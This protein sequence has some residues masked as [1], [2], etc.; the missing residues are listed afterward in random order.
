M[1]E[2]IRDVYN[3][4]PDKKDRDELFEKWKADQSQSNLREV[5]RGLEPTI[6]SAVRQYA[7]KDAPPTVQQRARILAARAV[8]SYDPTRGANLNT[9][10]HN[11][12]R[13]IQRMAP[14]ISDP[15]APNE[16]FRRQQMEISSAMAHIEDTLGREPT[17]EE[18]AEAT[19]LPAKRV[20]KVR[21]RMRARIP[22]SVYEDASDDE[23][24]APDI[25]GS[26]RT[27]YDEWIDA[28]YDDLGPVDRLIMMYRT[29]YR[30]A[31]ILDNNTIAQ[32]LKLSPSAVSQR[33][34]RIQSRLD[35]FHG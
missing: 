25:I 21:N 11:Q 32:R 10:V 14:S 22:I 19:G 26:E 33:V 20:T 35:S 23:D 12:L 29:G 7:G 2:T 3:E 1:A 8:R 18:V 28:V 30:G 34:R 9:H 31:D 17:D 4:R 24:G 27:P 5:V 6:A 13:R 15:L 16:R